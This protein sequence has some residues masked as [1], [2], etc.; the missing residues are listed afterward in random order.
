MIAGI[1]HILA[2]EDR[3]VAAASRE[4]SW[5]VAMPIHRNQYIFLDAMTISPY[6]PCTPMPEGSRLP[7]ELTDSLFRLDLDWVTSVPVEPLRNSWIIKSQTEGNG[8]SP[9]NKGR[10]EP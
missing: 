1:L 10:Y 6:S 5:I 7:G 3:V 8:T 9:N 4:L 2:C